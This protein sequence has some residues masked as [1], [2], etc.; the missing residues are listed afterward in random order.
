VKI[1]QIVTQMEGAGAQKV[2][3]Q[4]HEGLCNRGH[5]SELWFLYVKRPA[6]AGLRGVYS[7][8]NHR[9]SRREYFAI[10]AHLYGKLRRHAPDAVITHTH[11]A[12]VMGQVVAAAARV[13][14]RIAVHQNPLPTY[15]WAA[16]I[17]DC[18][19]GHVGTYSNI[20]AVSE[21]VVRSTDCYLPR[22]SRLVRLIHNCAAPATKSETVD[23]R[24]TW[25]IPPGKPILLSVGR[26]SRQKNHRTL[27]QALC[28]IPHAHLIV[29]GEGE[30]ASELRQQV[31][32]LS[33]GERVVFTGELDHK[34]VYGLMTCAD[35]FVFPSLW[36]GLSLAAVEALNAG[37]AT[38]ASDIPANRE[39]FGEAAVLVP[40]TDVDALASAITRTLADDLLA[41]ELRSKALRRARSFSMDTLIDK[42]EG[43]LC[44]Q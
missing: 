30:L 42:Y 37:M 33:L 1:V 12:N 22:Y 13:P 3:Y 43:L 32:A 27:F 29:A 24:A 7:I 20:V 21:T 14:K 25:G 26:L 18:L 40:P 15:P 11:Y 44:L 5:D 38:V 6:Y 34:Q 28:K 31:A 4:L 19:L 9:P 2:A 8:L 10:A 39:V 35:L 23:A 36:E 16:R 41:K 17:A